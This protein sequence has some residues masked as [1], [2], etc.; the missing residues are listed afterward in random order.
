MVTIDKK[1]KIKSVAKKGKIKEKVF[2]IRKL[3]GVKTILE[4]LF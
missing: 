4:L 3:D 2:Y 1:G